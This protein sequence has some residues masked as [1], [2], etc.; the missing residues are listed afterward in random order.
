M[1]SA[2]PRVRAGTPAARSPPF[3]RLET[4]QMQVANLPLVGYDPFRI[5]PQVCSGTFGTGGNFP[6]TRTVDNFT[7]CNTY[8]SFNCRRAPLRPRPK[9]PVKRKKP[10]RSPSRAKKPRNHPS[11]TESQPSPAAPSPSATT[12]ADERPTH[13]FLFKSESESR[14]HRGHEMKFSINDLQK[15]PNATAHWDGVRNAEACKCMRD[16]RKG[17]M[18]FFYHSNT[19]KTRPS[20]VGEVRVVSDPYPGMLLLRCCCSKSSSPVTQLVLTNRFFMTFVSDHTALD[21]NDP[22][23]DA[24]SKKDAPRWYMVDV[25]FVRKFQTAITLDQVKSEPKLANMQLVKRSRISVQRV[26]P[27]E[28]NVVHDLTT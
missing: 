1:E 25:Q 23:Y 8:D 27:E 17:D 19:K 4:F 11:T 26:T 21:Q 16:M 20:I 13:Y 22:H 5:I 9:P 24:R 18:A 7:R 2:W 15:E 28:W 14:M 12:A 6:S 3:L 10:Q